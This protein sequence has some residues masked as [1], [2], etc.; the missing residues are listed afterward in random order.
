MKKIILSCAVIFLISFVSAVSSCS[1][2]GLTTAINKQYQ[3]AYS[4]EDFLQ[5]YNIDLL[6][7]VSQIKDLNCL[8]YID[9]TDRT[10]K[11]DI[12]NLKDLN[13]LV[14][15]SFYSNPEVYGDICAISGLT[16]LKS[17]KFAFDPNITG[18]VACLKNLV[19]LESFAMTHTQ[20]SG[21]ISVFANMKNLK[22]IYISGT[23]IRGNICSLENL[24]N[25]EELG[26]A[27]EYPGNPD[28]YGDLSCLNNLKKLKRVAIY[29][30]NVA[31]CEEFTK[32]HP[33]MTQTV[34]ESGKQGGGGCSK[35]SM[36]TLV[37]YAQEYERKIGKEVQTEVRGQP[38]YG[39]NES[40]NKFDVRDEKDGRYNVPENKNFFGRIMGSIK[41]FFGR[42]FHRENRNQENPNEMPDVGPGGCRSQ[43]ECNAFCSQEANRETCDNFDK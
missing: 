31:N 3:M 40:E 8:E 20:I 42:I 30:T 22:A 15:L 33:N 21:D 9:A 13:N 26:I 18:D 43:A 12:F 25:L 2:N 41:S 35:E 7:D 6:K 34:T 29:N 37:D 23:Y 5:I 16:K 10:I 27:D 38:N 36:E 17:L 11:G 1:S 28:I 32:N 4:D 39:K 24:T 19:N 14:V